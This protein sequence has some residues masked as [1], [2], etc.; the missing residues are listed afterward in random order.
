MAAR[1]LSEGLPSAGLYSGPLAWLID[2]QANYA[3]VPW[4]CASKIQLV[5]LVALATAVLAMAGGY[6]SWLAYAAYQ[7]DE[8]DSSRGG[9]PHRF[10][11]LMSI[12]CA[13]L[14]TTII[15]AH[16]VAGLVFDG[17]ER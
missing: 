8:P 12:V 5:P 9:R 10:L 4:I 2:T 16:G 15:L 14:F 1:W 7:M 17:C 11:A 3:L 6:L 13:L